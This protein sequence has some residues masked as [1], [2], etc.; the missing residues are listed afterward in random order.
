MR[1]RERESERVRERGV[2]VHIS[3]ANLGRAH[4]PVRLPPRDCSSPGRPSLLK[5]PSDPEPITVADANWVEFLK[6]DPLIN[7][8]HLSPLIGPNR[9]AKEPGPMAH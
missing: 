6:S 1:E 9:P 7:L 8:A 4:K 3:A 5:N 2:Y